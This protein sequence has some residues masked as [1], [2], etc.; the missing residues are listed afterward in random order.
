MATLEPGETA[1][2]TAI[3]QLDNTVQRLMTLGLVEGSEVEMAG[4]APGG[5]PIEFKL[6]GCGISLR[7]EQAELFLVERTSTRG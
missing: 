6:F 1:V 7:R 3:R 4:R 5:D 2:I